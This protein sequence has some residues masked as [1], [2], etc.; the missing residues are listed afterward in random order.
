MR[1]IIAVLMV[2]TLSSCTLYD[3]VLMTKYDGDEYKAITGIRTDASLYANQCN[4]A[5]KSKANADNLASKTLYFSYFEESVPHNTDAANAAKSLDI[6][7]QG[8]KAR[9]N[10]GTPVSPMFCKIKFETVQHS[11]AVIQQV[12]GN[13]PR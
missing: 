1:N 8:L 11:S 7:A 10:S 4:D 5:V 12:M 13:R 3:A 6:I 2:L 9:Y